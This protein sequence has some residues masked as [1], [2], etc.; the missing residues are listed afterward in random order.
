MIL[1]AVHCIPRSNFKPEQEVYPRTDWGLPQCRSHPN[2]IL[3]AIQVLHLEKQL[4]HKTNTLKLQTFKPN[5]GTLNR[6]TVW[7]VDVGCGI[8]EELHS[9]DL[10]PPESSCTHWGNFRV[11]LGEWKRKWKLLSLRVAVKIMVP[12]WVP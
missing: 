6:S 7:P 2:F 10:I 3:R 8:Q 11:I 1:A 9:M 5:P 4:N 12:F